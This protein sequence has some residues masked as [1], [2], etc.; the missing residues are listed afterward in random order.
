MLNKKWLVL[1]FVVV[2][3]SHFQDTGVPFTIVKSLPSSVP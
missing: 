2:S 3:A 1:L